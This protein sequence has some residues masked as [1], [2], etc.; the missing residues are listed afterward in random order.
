MSERK[1]IKKAEIMKEETTRV[2]FRDR[3][4]EESIE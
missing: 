4:G 1:N 3:K 2:L